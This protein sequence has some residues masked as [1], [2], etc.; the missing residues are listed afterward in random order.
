[1]RARLTILIPL[2]VLAFGALRW[3][4]ER[5]LQRDQ[6]ARGLR[7]PEPV[8]VE[9]QQQVGQQAFAVALGGYRSVVAIWFTLRA[10]EAWDRLDWDELERDYRL[11]ATLQPRN[12]DIWR[13][14]GWHLAYNASV[15]QRNDPDLDPALREAKWREM[16]ARGEALLR[17]GAEQNPGSWELWRDLGMLWS[18]PLKIVD[19]DRALDSFRRGA[20]VPDSPR[21]LQRFVVYQQALVPEPARRREALDRIRELWA[22]PVNH[23]TALAEHRYF[24]EREFPGDP[25]D[26][27]REEF[28]AVFDRLAPASDADHAA[29]LERFL[30]D[31][32]RPDSAEGR[33]LIEFYRRRNRPEP[34]APPGPG[35]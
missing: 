20:G 12:V 2:A 22:D 30:R 5:G 3:P 31:T 16:V 18:D 21:W 15:A 13:M 23:V 11:A 28:I 26:W 9:L 4:L 25:R 35:D 33:A 32:G 10:F 34:A 7:A 8:A 19:R 14:G 6:I 17:E 24:L 27:S 29:I 1:M